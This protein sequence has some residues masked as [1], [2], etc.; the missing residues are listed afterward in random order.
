[1]TWLRH[2]LFLLALTWS[3]SSQ[4]IYECEDPS[5]EVCILRGVQLNSKDGGP[6]VLPE[7]LQFVHL[8][9][10]NIPKIEDEF[11]NEFGDPPINFTITNCAV[12]RLYVN[13]AV[14]HMNASW[15]KLKVV[16]VN[17]KQSYGHLRVLALSHNQLRKLP[18]IKDLI[19]LEKLDVSYNAIDYIDLHIFQRL[20]NLKTLDMGGNKITS[21][22]GQVR[23]EKLV[24]LRL[25]NNELHDVG[26]GTWNL[27]NLAT[28]DLSLNLLMYL[29]GADIQDFFPK[30]LYLGLPGNQ[31]NCRALPKL[32]D[33]LRERSV[34]FLVD[35]GKCP[36]NWTAVDGLCCVD[37]YVN[38]VTLHSQWEIRK[39]E[40]KVQ[41]LN[42]T[43]VADLARVKNE[44][45]QQIR[46]LEE[47]I[48]QQEQLMGNMKGHLLSMQGLIEDLI[49]EL[50]MRELEELDS[51]KG[52]EEKKPG[53]VK[54]VY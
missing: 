54:L 35:L 7:D 53:G 4:K 16:T 8:I 27:P 45:G 29:N 42:D 39:L 10:G 47:K 43:L 44:Q 25:N 38:W 3:V 41:T 24:E 15:N 40:R 1:M 36:A 21:L 19:Q 37:S 33:A 22:D 46:Q 23:L 9:D 13:P 2:F 51:K 20:T 32:L 48:D 31:W 30:L 11:Y 28:L 14:V 12:E 17:S 6:I 26:F 49:E 18:N 5:D 52:T 34:G 50:Y